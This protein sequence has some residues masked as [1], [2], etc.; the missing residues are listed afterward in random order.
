MGKRCSEYRLI[1]E[2]ARHLLKGNYK[3]VAA[4]IKEQ[5]LRAADNLEFELAASLRDRLNAVEALGQKQLVT[6]GTLADTD[7]VGYGE[8]ESKA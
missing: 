7:V 3:E 8:S 4:E 2:P 5:M 1:R 6:A